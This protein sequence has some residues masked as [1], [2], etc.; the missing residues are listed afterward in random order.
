MV[1]VHGGGTECTAV[2][3]R[4]GHTP[5]IVNGRRVTGDPDIE[6]AQWVLR[7]SA[8]LAL[9]ADALAQGLRAVGLSGVDGHLLR[10]RRRKSWTIDGKTVD[11][12]WVGDIDH[13]NPAIVDALHRGGFAPVI[14]PLAADAGGHIYNVN[15]DTVAGALAVA[16]KAHELLLVTPSGGLRRK[17]ND[18]NSHVPT[19]SAA[20]YREGLSAGWITDGMQVKMGVAVD[21]VASGVGTVFVLGSND[22]VN[23][24][25]ATRIVR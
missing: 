14:A 25:R 18:P 9:V 17:A 23:R 7:G 20:Q 15:A 8:N 4:L 16:L 6:I 22:L 3:R 12:G 24:A 5:Q 1:V 19:C 21:A 13:V 11:F 2:A 10:V